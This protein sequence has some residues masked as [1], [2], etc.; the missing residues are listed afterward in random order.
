[1]GETYDARVLARIAKMAPLL[2]DKTALIETAKQDISALE[3]YEIFEIAIIG[4]A[5]HEMGAFDND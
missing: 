3:I 5:L 4:S 2:G 1:M